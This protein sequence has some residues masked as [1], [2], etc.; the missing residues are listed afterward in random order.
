ANSKNKAAIFT[1]ILFKCS[2]KSTTMNKRN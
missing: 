2:Y 1:Q